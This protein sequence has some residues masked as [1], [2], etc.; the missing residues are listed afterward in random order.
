MRT[1]RDSQKPTQTEAE[2]ETETEAKLQG[3]KDIVASTTLTADALS[4]AIV[5]CSFVVGP[6]DRP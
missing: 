2:N 5:E 3:D 1:N 4:C 6:S